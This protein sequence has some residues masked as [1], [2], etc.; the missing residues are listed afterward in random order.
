[1][2]GDYREKGQ[3][4]GGNYTKKRLHRDGTRKKINNRGHIYVQ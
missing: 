1:M 4:E 2:G 3:Y